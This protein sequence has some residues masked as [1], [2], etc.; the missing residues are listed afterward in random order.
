[1]QALPLALIV[2]SS[3]ILSL[4]V[5]PHWR[6]RC[7]GYQRQDLASLLAC[8]WRTLPRASVA[9]DDTAR[10]SDS[11]GGVLGVLPMARAADATGA[12]PGRW[13][14]HS[15]DLGMRSACRCH[16]AAGR[17][18]ASAATAETAAFPR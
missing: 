5:R 1:M 10:A 2:Y 8:D 4:S 7:S 16:L 18:L 15:V 11:V 6:R 9:S 12:S 3:Q 17:R 13:T 14:I